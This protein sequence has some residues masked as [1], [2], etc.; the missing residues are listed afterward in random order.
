MDLPTPSRRIFGNGYPLDAAE[1]L[2]GERF[3]FADDV[4]DRAGRDDVAAVLARAGAEV[5]DVVGGAHYRL[6]VFDD[7]HGVA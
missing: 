5:N 1:V 2:A 4:R 3:G 7:K 6:V